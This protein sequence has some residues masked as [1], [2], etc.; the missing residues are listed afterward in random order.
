MAKLAGVS[1]ATVSRVL[2]GVGP[3]KEET[4]RKVREAAEQLGY[5]PSSIA[6]QFAKRKSGNIG[7]IL[8]YVPKVHLFSTYYFSE[9]LSGIGEAAGRLNNDLL[10]IFRDQRGPAD[11]AKLFRMRKIDSCIILGA[12]NTEQERS[13]LEE[14]NAEEF[15]FCLVNQRFDEAGYLSVDADHQAGSYEAVRH[16]I[17]GG[18]RRIAML[19]GPGLY[20]NSLDRYEGYRQALSEAGLEAAAD[21]LFTGNYSSKSGYAAAPEIAVKVK[22]GE[23]DAIFAAN[24]RM[25]L[26]LMNGLREL[27][28]KAGEDVALIGYDNS[29]GSKFV[30]PG[31]S[32]VEVPFFEMGQK[33]AELLLAD[34][35]QQPANLVLPV[36]LIIRDS[37]VRAHTKF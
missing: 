14:L 12:Q 24:D 2:N 22:N 7:V 17:A 15:A 25:A 28:V 23:I 1:E 8:P 37:S 3:I 13:A 18:C 9:I 35:G 26:G 32:T 21:R 16:L 19:N 30:H 6:R 5:V 29:D 11:Y 36:S 31:L 4:R 10:L 27:G 20:S 33:A 34:D